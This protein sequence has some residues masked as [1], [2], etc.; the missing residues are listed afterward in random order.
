MNTIIP[1]ILTALL[2]AGV[3]VAADKPPTKAELR[4]MSDAK[5]HDLVKSLYARI[6]ELEAQRPG[7]KKPK[8]AMPA[9]DS[10]HA[11]LSKLY[12]ARGEEYRQWLLGRAEGTLKSA[13]AKVAASRKIKG[14]ERRAYIDQWKPAQI[15]AQDRLDYLESVKGSQAPRLGASKIRVGALGVIMRNNHDEY[16]PDVVQII[17]DD[18][19]IIRVIDS[20]IWLTGF[21]TAQLTDGKRHRLGGAIW[22]NGTKTYT[23]AWGGTKTV[24]TAE[25]FVPL[26]HTP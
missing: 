12:Y 20:W 19:M 15:K 22:V 16:L 14:R 23:T 1:T 3:A 25:R 10:E 17:D 26:H 4:R 21:P 6:A 5:I 18:E 7:A 2:S 9:P 8:A 24:F 13:K 11:R